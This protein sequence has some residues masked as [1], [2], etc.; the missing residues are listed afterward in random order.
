MAGVADEIRLENL[1]GWLDRVSRVPDTADKEPLFK[2]VKQAL[3]SATKRNFSEGHGPNG[4]LWPGLKHRE[5][6]PLRDKGLLMASVFG[7]GHV[8]NATPN[9]L[10]WGTNLS[11]AAI[12]QHGGTIVPKNA[13]ALAIPLTREAQRAGSPRDFKRPLVL[14]KRQGKPSLLVTTK[15]KGK[16]ARLE[17]Q[18]ILLAS[19]TIPVRPFL[20]WSPKLTE[21][22]QKLTGD[23]FAR[24]AAKVRG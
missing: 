21:T 19:V 7:A 23:W 17:P 22:V 24:E 8:E 16:N 18:Y 2:R 5:G 6:K 15:G 10:T 4:E 12:H 1:P 13:K 9:T 11:Y 3:V 14:L 20:G